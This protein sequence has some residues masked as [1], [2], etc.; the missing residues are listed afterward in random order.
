MLIDWVKNKDKHNREK[1]VGYLTTIIETALE[2][3]KLHKD[4]TESTRY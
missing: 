4:K 2:S 3:M 1:T